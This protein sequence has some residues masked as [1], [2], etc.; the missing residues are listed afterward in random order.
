MSLNKKLWLAII[1][2]LILSS[3]G[4]FVLSTLFSKYYLEEQLQVKN[5][6]NANSLALSMSQLPK[7]SATIDLLISAQFD[8]GHYEYIGLFNPLGELLTERV[9]TQ[10]QTKAPA[11]FTR[12]FT[13]KIQTG[14]AEVQD[15]WSQYGTLKVRS[16]LNFAYDKLWESTLFIALW[17]LVIGLFSCYVG[18]QTLR[19]ILDPLKDIVNQA[20]AIGENRFITIEEPKTTEF[21]AVVSAMNTLSNRIKNNVQDESLR[22]EKLRYQANFDQITGLMNHHYFI[23]SMDSNIAHEEHFNQGVLIISRLT[24]LHLIDQSMGY[25]ETNA[26]LKLIG[27]TLENACKSQ[28]SLFAG[29]LNGTDF[30]LFSTTALDPYAL[31]NQIKSLLEKLHIPSHSELD[32]RFISAATQVTKSD[33]ATKLVARLD[34]ALDEIDVSVS[35]H[36]L[37]IINE[38]AIPSDLELSRIEWEILL[39]SA[40]TNK[41]IKFQHYPVVNQM[42]ELIHFESPV[43]LQLQKNANWLCAGEFLVWAHQLNLMSRLDELVVETAI[44]SL[45]IGAHPIGLNVSAEALCDANFTEKVVKLI[46]PNLSIAH[47]LY[48]EVPEKGVFDHFSAFK[49]FCTTLKSLGCKIGIEHVG[50]RISSLGELHDVGLDYI[51]IDASLIR[52]IHQNEANKTLLGGLCM[53]AHSIGVL[54]IAEGVQTISEIEAL[55]L[56][57]IDGMTG[58]GIKFS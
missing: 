2:I 34:S 18:S 13:I 28:P 17:S 25:E 49:R 56:I 26:F 48:F 45:S 51:K 46:E 15:G 52:D 47:L 10:S 30:A 43:R 23:K 33:I 55:K 39:N 24:N 50:S 12:I 41:R 31:G 58:P 36:I 53:I 7:D 37:H 3:G 14:V 16:N 9:N 4:S 8:A 22:L 6:D 42:G 57:G 32:A 35:E 54:A 11:W 19:K 40:F 5:I 21:K 20:T 1:Y 38:D 44:E 29:R 27:E